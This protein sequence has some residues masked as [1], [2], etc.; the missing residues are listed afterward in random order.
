MAHNDPSKDANSS[1][2]Q[3]QS[4]VAKLKFSHKG[5]RGLI[6]N[7][8]GTVEKAL[9]VLLQATCKTTFLSCV[10]NSTE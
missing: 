4:V 6:S 10:P 2:L 1:G 7:S 5:T 8:R 9:A 3:V